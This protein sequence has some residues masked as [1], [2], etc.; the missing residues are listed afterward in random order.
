MNASTAQQEKLQLGFSLHYRTHGTLVIG[1]PN[2]DRVGRQSIIP[3][4]NLHLVLIVFAFVA[5]FFA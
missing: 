2:V 4:S 3:F 5:G 1:M